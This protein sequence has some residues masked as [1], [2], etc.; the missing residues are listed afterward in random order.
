MKMQWSTIADTIF[1]YYKGQSFNIAHIKRM[2][3][4]FLFALQATNAFFPCT[5]ENISRHFC[6]FIHTL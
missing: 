1:V 5:Q 2:I 6:D 3:L 4:K